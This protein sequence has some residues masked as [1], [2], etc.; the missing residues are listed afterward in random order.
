MQKF[1]RTIILLPLLMADLTSFTIK[2]L[3]PP[4]VKAIKI[5][6][7]IFVRLHWPQTEQSPN[8]WKLHV[9]A[10]DKREASPKSLQNK[11]KLEVIKRAKNTWR[12]KV[13][14]PI[15]Q[16]DLLLYLSLNIRHLT[17][18]TTHTHSEISHSCTALLWV[19]HFNYISGAPSTSQ[20]TGWQW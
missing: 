8:T 6:P 14:A 2:Y 20:S 7:F 9:E 17:H 19:I 4:E 16:Q 10:S 12:I 3:P 5:L 18:P 15:L 11:A 13:R 1:L